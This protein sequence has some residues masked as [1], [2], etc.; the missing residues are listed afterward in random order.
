MNKDGDGDGREG[1]SACVHACDES[2]GLESSCDGQAGDG[3]SAS[4]LWRKMEK[5]KRED[6]IYRREEI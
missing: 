1:V 3:L 6:E 5:K 2:G 4:K